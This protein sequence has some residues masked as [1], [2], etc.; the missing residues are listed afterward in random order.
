MRTTSVVLLL[1]FLASPHLRA[2]DAVRSGRFVVEPST[3]ICL[4]FEWEIAGD[5][6]RNASVEVLFRK[7]ADSAWKNALPLLRMGGERI[8]QDRTRLPLVSTDYTVPEMFAGSILDL[9]PNTEYEVRLTMRDPD[10]VRGNAVESAKVRTRSEPKAAEGGRVLHV[11][12]PGWRG[13]KQE[14][15]YTGLMAA[16][17][18]SGI[19]DWIG[20]RDH[21]L[22][23][24]DIILVHAGLYRGNRLNVA[25]VLSLPFDG[26]YLLTAKGTPDKPIVIRAAG[27]GEVIFDGDGCHQLFNVMA[28]DYHIFEGLTIRNTDIAFFGGLKG[29]VGSKGL[30]VRD[31]RIEDVG[32]GISTKYEGS[33][34]Y[35]I[36]DNVFLGRDDRYRLL[37]WAGE[38]DA[39]GA[40]LLKTFYAVKVYGSG[41]VIC[42]NYIAY[43]HDGI[44]VSTHDSPDPDRDRRAVAIDIYNND[45]Y[46]TG[47]DFIEADG[48]VHNIRVMRNRGVNSAQSGLSAQPVFGGPAYFVRN[49]LYNLPGGSALKFMAKPAG[50]FVYHNTFITENGNSDPFSNAHFRNNLFLGGDAPGRGI[51]VFPNA[52][53]YSTYDYNGYRPNR[54]AKAQFSWAAPAEGRLRDYGITAKDFRSYQTLAELSKATGQEAHGVEVDYDIFE[55]LRPPDP[56]KSHA[57]YRATDLNF[58]LR[59]RS[60]AVDAGVTLPNVNDDFTG[61]AP[62]LGAYEVGK[63]EPVYG[64][65]EGS[66]QQQPSYR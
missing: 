25:D 51:A 31:C 41:H 3:L 9:E 29:V 40:K 61:K 59:Q 53:S 19:G 35:Y 52:T 43:F 46:V 39:Y 64:P 45:I 26:T 65:R 34:D 55:S 21:A 33:K 13:K 36:A 32:I 1:M 24:G 23:P 27:D 20:V 5:D 66:G 2:E 10:G 44:D 8:F 37:G 30:T 50:L 58:R 14:P 63:P 18:G 16:Y 60:K 6:N 62:D 38:R 11:Y 12:P 22:N 15:A 28:A 49:V 7:T 48:G 57:L 42:N 4:G 47:D 56:A 17:Q 54:Q